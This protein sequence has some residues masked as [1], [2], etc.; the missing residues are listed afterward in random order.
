ME[1][2]SG[3]GMNEGCFTLIKVVLCDSQLLFGRDKFCI[4]PTIK[5]ICG[6]R[7]THNRTT[8][9]CSNHVSQMVSFQV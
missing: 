3:V 6:V 9:T 1:G 5:V 8:Y 2:T 7:S 4:L